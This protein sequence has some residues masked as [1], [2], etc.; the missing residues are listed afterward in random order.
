MKPVTSFLT[1]ALALCAAAFAHAA[2]EVGKPAPDFSLTDLDGQTH[3]LSSFKGKTVVLE[4]VNPDC[5]FVRKHYEKSTNLPDTQKS[6]ATD[7]VVWLQI[8]SAAAGK[9][10]DFNA[11]KAKAWQQRVGVQAAAYL[12]D[13]DGKVGHLYDAR[14]TPH[15]FII[16][17]AG[18]LVYQGGIDSIRSA[19][20]DD[21]AKATNYVRAA[22]AELKAGK[23]VTHASTPPYGCSVKY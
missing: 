21:I 15:L 18:T 7:G 19:N 9:E 1:V 16:D 5:P 22:L 2:L 23:A 17:P 12:R 8:N 14:T 4:W 20:P 3:A 13:T 6:A 11:A 10:G